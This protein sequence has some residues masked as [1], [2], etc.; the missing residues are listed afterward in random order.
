M[1]F[2][3]AVSTLFAASALAAPA[4]PR[5]ETKSMMAAAEWTIESLKRTCDSGDTLCSWEFGINTGAVTA[6]SFSVSGS[7]ASHTDLVSAATCGDFSVT[8]GW[9]DQFGADNGFTTL[10]VVDNVNRLIVYPAY[11]DKQLVNGVVV[12]PNQ[13]YTPQA[14]P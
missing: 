11:T 5:A 2:T 14:L 7:P 6:C 13:S 1:H 3:A 8:T 4:Q 12:V 10:A 9:S